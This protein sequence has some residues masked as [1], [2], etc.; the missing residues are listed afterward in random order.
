MHD[1]DLEG[2]FTAA[3]RRLD[4]LPLAYV[5]TVEPGISGAQSEGNFQKS[6]GCAWVKPRTRHPLIATGNFTGLSGAA[7][8]EA[9][10][11]NV[12][13]F[14]RHFLANP[15]LPA[16]LA[17]GWELNAPDRSTFYGGSEAGY[18]D[19]PT[20]AGQE[21]QPACSSSPL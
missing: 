7:A 9:G 19:Y 3:L 17:R 20:Y 5:H 2:L 4:P 12:I 21:E 11:A 10:R 14:G 16:R 13:G 6:L 1:P 18:T 15:D 8:V